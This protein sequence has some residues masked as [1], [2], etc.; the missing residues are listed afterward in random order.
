MWLTVEC[1][2]RLLDGKPCRKMSN[3]CH[4]RLI[5]PRVYDR[6]PRVVEEDQKGRDGF[7]A[8]SMSPV[9]ASMALPCLR[10]RCALGGAMRL[11]PGRAA[12]PVLPAAPDPVAIETHWLG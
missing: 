4:W 11:Q 7:Y 5:R 3:L 2:D 10:H 8:S 1:P 6:N 12:T 9:I